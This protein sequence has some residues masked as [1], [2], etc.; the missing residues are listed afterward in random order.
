[1]SLT[2]TE[3][4]YTAVLVQR[5]FKD[6]ENGEVVLNTENFSV[7]QIIHRKHYNIMKRSY[8]RKL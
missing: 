6:R 8:S 7:L 3:Y 4:P 1:M 2:Y 5:R